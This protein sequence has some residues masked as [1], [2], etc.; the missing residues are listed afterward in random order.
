MVSRSKFAVW[1]VAAIVAVVLATQDVLAAAA[2]YPKHEA[3]IPA[4]TLALMT[5]RNTAAASPILIRTYK[6]EAELEIWK[7]AK[8]GRFVLLK[9][10]PICRWSGQLGPKLKQGDRQ[11]PEGFYSVSSEQMN[12]NS[13]YHLSFDIGY[14]NAY[15]RAHGAS[16]AYLMV[17]GACSSAGCYA[18]TDK[19]IEEIYA[20]AREAFA[21][22]QK[23]FQFQS[24]PFRMTARNMAR[25]RS[26]PNI[27]FWRQLKEGSDRFE[28]TRQEPVVS[29][30]GGR[31]VF[32]PAKDPAKEA[33]AIARLSEEEARIAALI[34]EG[35]AAVRTTYA[36]GGQHPSFAAP[37]RQG[38]SLG[39]VSRPETLAFAGREVVITPARPK[40]P[41]CPG[42]AC[43]TQV[44]EAT[45]AA[46][47]VTSTLQ[48][49][50]WTPRIPSPSP[51]SETKL[52]V[53]SPTPL[54]YGPTQPMPYRS[55]P[56]GSVR[57]LPAAL[58]NM[59]AAVAAQP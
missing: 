35:S 9:T 20:I 37:A 11:A 1:R 47:E 51:S 23:A 19:A 39:L 3:P 16:G 33:L 32:G 4:A 50:A 43:P 42:P 31:Y 27:A 30:S 58:A 57:I 8:D 22:G 36:D 52:S 21:G 2:G 56:L 24:Y 10:F 49:V 45:A 15:D 18:M 40:R 12:P 54:G 26:D 44:A 25:H 48:P 5:A 34:A 29:V 28:A 38:T 17:H 55:R 53:F 13:S 7:K 46:P 41:A 6:K 14:P 59:T